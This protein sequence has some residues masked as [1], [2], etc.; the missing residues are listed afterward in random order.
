MP[1]HY[2][3]AYHQTSS[4]RKDNSMDS[5]VCPACTAHRSE[6]WL[7]PSHVGPLQSQMQVLFQSMTVIAVKCQVIVFTATED[8]VGFKAL[9]LLQHSS[10]LWAFLKTIRAMHSLE[11]LEQSKSG[12]RVFLPHRF[13]NTVECI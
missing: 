5:S 2:Y 7:I 11:A 8:Y 9:L 6:V 3:F 10:K 4:L 13:K 12:N 1:N